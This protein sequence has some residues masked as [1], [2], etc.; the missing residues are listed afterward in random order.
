MLKNL[1]LREAVSKAKSPNTPYKLDFD[2]L[3]Q[4]PGLCNHMK[5]EFYFQ[6]KAITMNK[7]KLLSH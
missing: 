1:H 4:W 5:D 7:A 6:L 2:P 3:P